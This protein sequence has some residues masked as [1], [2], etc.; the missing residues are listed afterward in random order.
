MEWLKIYALIFLAI[1]VGI[2]TCTVS[3]AFLYWV[4]MPMG[5]VTGVCAGLLS[6]VILLPALFYLL[7]KYA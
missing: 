2:G 7:D 5:P 3:V 1:A 6:A 4:G